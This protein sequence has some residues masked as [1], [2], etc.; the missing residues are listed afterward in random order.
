MTEVTVVYIAG[1]GRSGS[2]LLERI[3]SSGPGFASAGEAS[4]FPSSVLNTEICCS[5]GAVLRECPQWSNVIEQIEAEETL[6][7]T[8]LK[9]RLRSYRGF[10]SLLAIPLAQHGS[11]NACYRRYHRQFYSSL[12]ST[13][14]SGSCFVVDSSKS[15]RGNGLRPVLLSRVAGLNVVVLHLVRDGRATIWSQMRGSNRKIEA[16]VDPRMRWPV[17]RSVA[18]WIAANLAAQLSGRWVRERKYMR[19]RYEDLIDSPA[20]T[21]Q[22][23]GLF[24]EADLSVQSD[25]LMN[26]GAIPLAHQ[27][28]GNRLRLQSRLVLKADMEWQSKLAKRW[29]ILFWIAAGALARYYGYGHHRRGASAE[30]APVTDIH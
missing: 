22:A 12:A 13:A 29:R 23:I 16:G 4:G 11:R 14:A 17:L 30:D 15:A 1:Y 21:L 6:D 8:G 20:E 28:Q 19:I 3:L 25:L 7:W 10:R 2:T 26:G 24:L 27:V 18:G 5:C 9:K